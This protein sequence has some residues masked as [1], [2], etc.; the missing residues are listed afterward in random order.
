MT[1]FALESELFCFCLIP[2]YNNNNNNKNNSKIAFH[3]WTFRCALFFGKLPFFCFRAAIFHFYAAAAAGS[4]SNK[5]NN[6]RQ[7]EKQVGF[8]PPLCKLTDILLSGI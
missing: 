8:V 1:N 4:N 3:F 2:M 7:P 5:N 6:I